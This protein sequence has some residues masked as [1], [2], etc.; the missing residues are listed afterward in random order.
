VIVVRGLAVRGGCG[1]DGIVR[2]E[3]G[4]LAV[5]FDM[6]DVLAALY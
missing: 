3:K 5:D 2:A 6:R 1:F 4:F